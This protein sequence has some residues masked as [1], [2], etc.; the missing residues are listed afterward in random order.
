MRPF[1]PQIVASLR[2]DETWKVAAHW[3]ENDKLGLKIWTANGFWF[4]Y[5]EWART[6]HSYGGWEP[7]RRV[8]LTL[9][10]K[11]VIWRAC[12]QMLKDYRKRKDD[13]VLETII[14]RRLTGEKK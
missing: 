8:D 11:F 6:R 5:F 3:A 2:E 13:F 14:Q 10:E 1:V 12:K 7:G 9:P 4:L